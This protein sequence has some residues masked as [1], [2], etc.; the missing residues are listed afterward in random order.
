MGEGEPGSRWEAGWDK[1]KGQ[2]PTTD[3]LGKAG[4]FQFDPE[5]TFVALISAKVLRDTEFISDL[6]TNSIRLFRL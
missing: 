3:I 4:N 5:Q 2:P 1:L 6:H